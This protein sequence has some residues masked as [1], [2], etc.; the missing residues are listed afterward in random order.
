MKAHA[1]PPRPLS[2]RPRAIALSLHLFDSAIDEALEHL[3]V[4][5]NLERYRWLPRSLLPW[6]RKRRYGA[7]HVVTMSADGSHVMAGDLWQVGQ[8]VNLTARRK[9]GIRRD[10][11]R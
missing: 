2:V 4:A 9:D 11:R 10:A 1:T 8:R 3:Q 6:K 5:A 7:K